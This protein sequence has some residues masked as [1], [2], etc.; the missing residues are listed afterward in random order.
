MV[1]HID[2]V[3]TND[4][5]SNLEWVIKL[6]ESKYALSKSAPIRSGTPV[7]Q[8]SLEGELINV[9]PSIAEAARITGASEGH[10]PSVCRGERNECGGFKWEYNDEAWLDEIEEPEGKEIEGYPN[11]VITRE[12]TVYS[13]NIGRFMELQKAE[14]GYLHVDLSNGEPKKRFYVHDLVAIAFLERVSGKNQVNHID[15]DKGKDNNHVDNLEWVT[16]SE[17]MCHHICTN[18]KTNQVGVIMYDMKGKELK[19]YDKIRDAASDETR[20]PRCIDAS[21]IVRVCKGKQTHAGGFLWRYINE[22]RM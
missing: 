2:G 20:I 14:D 4:F 12:G 18:P 6:N 17:N 5:S 21:S 19:R 13:K 22:N 15:K 9:F 16:G 10:I 3:R 1:C 7:R 11:Y 8:L